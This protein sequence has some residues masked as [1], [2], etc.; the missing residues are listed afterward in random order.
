MDPRETLARQSAYVRE[1]YCLARRRLD[2]K[3]GKMSDFGS[4][5]IPRWDGGL[6]EDSGTEH[7]P[8]WPRIV[9]FCVDNKLEPGTLVRAVFDNHQSPHP[10]APTSLLSDN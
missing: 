4:Q 3:R 9:K 2:A 7:Q 5:E 6:D 1:L 10:P 8:I